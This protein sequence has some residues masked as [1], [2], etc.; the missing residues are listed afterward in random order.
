MGIR[1]TEG[2]RPRRPQASSP[3]NGTTPQRQSPFS[4]DRGCSLPLSAPLKSFA[5]AENASRSRTKSAEEK[6][7]ASKNLESVES[8]SAPQVRG[9][10][11]RRRNL[12]IRKGNAG[13][14]ATP[15]LSLN[16]GYVLADNT[17]YSPNTQQCEDLHQSQNLWRHALE[18]HGTGQPLNASYPI[19]TLSGIFTDDKFLQFK[20]A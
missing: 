12:T 19:F 14:V 8:P 7:E 20:N 5:A 9:C 18:S 15:K 1:N 13:S 11:S 10:L 2:R 17:N 4:P 16:T 6:A 3:A